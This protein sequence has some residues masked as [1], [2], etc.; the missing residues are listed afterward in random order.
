[1]HQYVYVSVAFQCVS[2]P[3][4]CFVCFVAKEE[5][6]LTEQEAGQLKKTL[7]LWAGIY[8]GP[9]YPSA[10]ETSQ[11]LAVSGSTTMPPFNF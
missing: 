7:K 2:T 9:F 10:E 5:I 3:Y 6:I 4:L 8:S 11:V 1:M